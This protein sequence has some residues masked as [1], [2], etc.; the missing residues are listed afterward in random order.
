M[1]PHLPQIH[2][3]PLKPF[4]SENI[5][6]TVT[7]K[8]VRPFLSPSSLSSIPQDILDTRFGTYTPLN[9]VNNFH[10]SHNYIKQQQSSNP[11]P[12]PT[13]QKD[14]SLPNLPTKAYRFNGGSSISTIPNQRLN[15]SKSQYSISYNSMSSLDGDSLSLPGSFILRDVQNQQ[16]KPS[17]IPLRTE[18]D[19]S[20][21]NHGKPSF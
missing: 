13:L 20:S 5:P 3:P 15:N 10:F 12:L 9:E 17:R 18:A 11:S 21:T 6:T 1:Q 2:I 7:R 14:S 16:L 8:L 19:Y 4:S